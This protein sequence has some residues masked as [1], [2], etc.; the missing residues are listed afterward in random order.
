MNWQSISQVVNIIHQ[1]V[2]DHIGSAQ[3]TGGAILTFLLALEIMGEAFDLSTGRGFKL[4]KRLVTWVFCAAFIGA[5]PQV[6]N[7]I[8]SAATALGAQCFD[9]FTDIK[10]NILNQQ[11]MASRAIAM[12]MMGG[13][14]AVV[15]A[16]PAMIMFGLGIL[17]M[18]VALMIIYVMLAGAFAALA[19][20]IVLGPV[21]I[22]FML[23][24][25]TRGLFMHW[26]SS[27]LSFFLMIPMYGWAITITVNIFFDA[28]NTTMLSFTGM[29]N[30]S[31]LLTLILGPFTCIGIAMHV[32]K[33][34]HSLL[35]GSG[36]A[37]GDMIA[38]AASIGGAAG[39]ARMIAARAGG[40]A[41]GGGGGAG[42]GISQHIQA[43]QGGK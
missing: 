43:S 6:A 13:I 25:I 11:E 21:F 1:V 7:G 15:R 26:V 8:W 31:H 28:A 37:G 4:D 36:G 20:V 24:S 16:I 33:I 14:L 40:G 41:A 34:A 12:N 35:G 23:N 10:Q 3:L 19:F 2:W 38:G 30:G 9:G 42:G 39:G 18:M 5:Y 22:P 27:I 17:L 32:P 29:P